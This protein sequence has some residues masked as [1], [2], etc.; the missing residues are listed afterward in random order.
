MPGG[1]LN[2]ILT[3]EDKTKIVIEGMGF[4]LSSNIISSAQFTAMMGEY[5]KA[6][7]PG[8]ASS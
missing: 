8:G 4:W 2:D 6:S 5:M 7:G 3:S 1:S